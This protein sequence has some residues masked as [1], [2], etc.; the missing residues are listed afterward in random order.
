M[1]HDKVLQMAMSKFAIGAII[2]MA[3][4]GIAITVAT[5]A[6]LSSTQNVQYNGTVS[7]VNVGVYS[8]PA[9]TN[10]CT[11]INAGTTSPGNSYT[12]TVYV[13]NTGNAPVTLSMATS[14]WNPTTANGP[15]T[16][17][18]NRDYYQLAAGD[19]VDAKLT[20]SVSSSIS[21]SIINFS[22]NIAITG[23]G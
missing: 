7:A 6:L 1:I 22:F 8:N 4:T 21:S 16:M 10:N 9:C 20:L 19:S 11:Q 15:I 12:Y 18:W 13:K 5:S 3:I 17:T 14:G 23:T 2:A